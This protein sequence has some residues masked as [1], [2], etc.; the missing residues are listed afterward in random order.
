M[1]KFK[2]NITY[3]FEDADTIEEAE[4]FAK[5]LILEQHIHGSC[6]PVV[7]LIRDGDRSAANLL[8]KTAD[9]LHYRNQKVAITEYPGFNESQRTYD[10][11]DIREGEV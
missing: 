4:A 9:G 10:E 5:I 7:S 2:L 3:E 11:G 1:A 6:I 8:F